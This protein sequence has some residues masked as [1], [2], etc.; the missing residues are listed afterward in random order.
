MARYPND[1]QCIQPLRRLA[2]VG[3]SF[4]GV[5]LVGVRLVGVSLVGVRLVGVRLHELRFGSGGSCDSAPVLA[6]AGQTVRL[7]STT[8]KKIITYKKVE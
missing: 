4:V 3:F 2:A 7:G 6:L 8:L 5:R 1:Q